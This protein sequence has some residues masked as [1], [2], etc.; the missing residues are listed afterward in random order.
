MTIGKCK[1]RML[2]P[3]LLILFSYFPDANSEVNLFD[4]A[5]AKTHPSEWV[6][7]GI[8]LAIGANFQ[9]TQVPTV[10]IYDVSYWELD[11]FA[12]L[13]FLL[14]SE[15]FRIGI[16]DISFLSLQPNC[17]FGRI[18][19]FTFSPGIG[20]HLPF[21]LHPHADMP[22]MLFLVGLEGGTNLQVQFGDNA[23]SRLSTVPFLLTYFNW[24]I[25]MQNGA[26]HLGLEPF[27]RL[28]YSYKGIA[29]TGYS[30][31]LPEKAVWVQ[32]GLSISLELF[33]RR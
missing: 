1:G 28:N 10:S 25:P 27:I 3:V 20:F 5:A 9:F 21:Y 18:S 29:L 12:G 24:L 17:P 8:P 30:G 16:R 4:T 19:A 15:H 26:R 22:N 13:F 7:T 6:S 33:D 32:A 14:Y 2:F 11:G 23:W 31:S